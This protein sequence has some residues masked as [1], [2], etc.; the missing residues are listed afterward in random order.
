MNQSAAFEFKGVNLQR[1]HH[2]KKPELHCVCASAPFVILVQ[3]HQ[4]TEVKSREHKGRQH[5][6][7]SHM[8]ALCP[9]FVPITSDVMAGQVPLD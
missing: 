5:D 4:P 9:T 7:K 8:Q 1:I 6:H 3:V 2:I